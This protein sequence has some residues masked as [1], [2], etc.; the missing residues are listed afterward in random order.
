MT[1]GWSAYRELFPVTREWAYLKNAANS[2]FC[3]LATDAMRHVLAVGEGGQAGGEVWADKLEEIRASAAR[4]IGATPKEVCFVNNTSEGLNIVANG[5]DWHPGDNIVT[6][7]TEFPANIYPW[8][9]LAR[10]GV[11]LRFAPAQEN[12]IRVQDI[13]AQM[14]ERT[15]LVAISFVEFGTGFRND[16]VAI[17]Q[18]CRQRGVFF[19]VDSIQGLGALPLDVRECQIDFLANGGH[20]WLLGTEGTGIFFC[21]Q[22]L[23]ARLTLAVVGWCSVQAMDDYYRYDSPLRD[24][25]TRWE[26][27][28]S[29]FIGR[30]GLGAGIKLL[31]EAG[32]GN[33]EQRL[34]DLTDYLI[35]G[36]Q[37][38]GYRVTSPIAS[39]A[40][41]SGILC[42]NHP[43]HAAEALFACLM[44]AKVAVSLRG[45]V[46]RVAPHFYNNEEDLDRLL[47]ALPA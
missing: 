34:F 39:R 17:G 31:Q 35:V 7:E 41:R 40:E 36:L 25:A 33:I 9:N 27:G 15:R 19:C 1:S 23:I 8:K 12:R 29:N 5:L 22:E 2:P 30:I 3:T 21:R 20:K 14:D 42:F 16:L 32:I 13:A 46:I 37:R 47:L 11:E 43:S 44:A 4:L 28:C 45:Q 10:L 18:L 38:K 6:A 26:I 24:D